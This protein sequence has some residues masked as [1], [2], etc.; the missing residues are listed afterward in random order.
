MRK[1]ASAEPFNFL[2]CMREIRH[3]IC[4]QNNLDPEL[5]CACRGE[6]SLRAHSQTRKHWGR[7]WQAKLIVKSVVKWQEFC[8]IKNIATTLI[9]C[10]RL[11]QCS[12]P[13]KNRKKP[14]QFTQRNVAPARRVLHV[15]KTKYRVSYRKS[16]FSSFLR[17]HRVLTI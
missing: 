8:G 13:V 7:E 5:F 12:K 6:R 4:K 2:S 11:T 16:R 9:C 15:I 3:A 10:T 1:V 17:L 14:R